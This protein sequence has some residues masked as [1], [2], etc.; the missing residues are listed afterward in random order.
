MKH[1]LLIAILILSSCSK[2]ASVPET[3]SS[4]DQPTA[5]TKVEEVKKTVKETLEVEK[6]TDKEKL[7]ILM[8]TAQGNRSDSF[9]DVI[10][11]LD[12]YGETFAYI[13]FQDTK[14]KYSEKAV[15][16][17]ELLN[18]NATL[19]QK[20][21]DQ[22][23]NFKEFFHALGIMDT[24]AIG[25]SH[26]RTD[27]G[28]IRNKFAIH[29]RQSTSPSLYWHCF[30]KTERFDSIDFLPSDT[31]FS[32][33]FR[34]NF[35]VLIEL[36]QLVLNSFK[37]DKKPERLSKVNEKIT[38]L[39]ELNEILTGEISVAVFWDGQKLELSTEKIPEVSAA[40]IIKLK[41]GAELK[42]VN[43]INWQKYL[44][45][46]DGKL[47]LNNTSFVRKGQYVILTDK[48]GA[49][50]FSSDKLLIEEDSFK[51]K[52][53][54]LDLKGSMYSY[55]SPV[56]TNALYDEIAK[57]SPPQ[58]QEVLD[59]FMSKDEFNYHFLNVMESRP[60][61]FYYSGISSGGS[62][63]FMVV[64]MMSSF[65]HHLIFMNEI[66]SAEDIN[67]WISK[68]NLNEIN[69]LVGQT[70]KKVSTLKSKTPSKS[71]ERSIQETKKDL[72]FIRYALDQY[73]KKNNA[74]YPSPDGAKGLQ[75]LVK[76]KLLK[77]SEYLLSSYDEE[78]SKPTSSNFSEFEVSYLYLGNEI[79][80]ATASYYYPLVITKP[81]LMGKE[82]LAIL[83]NNKIVHF[84]SGGESLSTILSTLNKAYKYNERQKSI[85]R[86]KFNN[87]KD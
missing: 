71:I 48:A 64:N 73:Q 46:F 87:V 4:K 1:I 11:F 50:S 79:T 23:N 19:D 85:L 5:Q 84:K 8:Q 58:F 28:M 2:K 39:K 31:A 65:F 52:L 21:I 78:R 49:K 63:S 43:S 17:W 55:L 80:K 27:S 26:Y 38:F 30:G 82:F 22:F 60:E 47:K 51:A 37:D 15:K 3:V 32:A 86:K 68:V 61:G 10:S 62:Y 35:E 44:D 16:L 6:L 83:A 41:E 42:K 77:K 57:E 40:L 76:M 72:E 75:K 45:L 34:V 18:A 7:K 29:R 56:I 69:S 20:N 59:I 66:D 14:D 70:V 9:Q 33:G 67:Q 81:K 36:H 25:L 12:P 24:D 53:K 74:F 54:H 13:N